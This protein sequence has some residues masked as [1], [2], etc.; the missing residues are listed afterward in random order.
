MQEKHKLNIF[1]VI[2]NESIRNKLELLLKA[3]E[4]DHYTWNKSSMAAVSEMS[5]Q[6]MKDALLIAEDSIINVNEEFKKL[7]TSNSIRFPV[8]IATN[9]VNKNLAYTLM[10]AGNEGVIIEELLSEK[11][12]DDLITQSVIRKDIETDLLERIQQ[13]V[14]KSE[15]KSIFLSNMSHEIRNPL[16]VIVGIID[17]LNEQLPPSKEILLNYVSTMDKAASSLLSLVNGI[18]DLSKIEEGKIELNKAVFN[19]WEEIK[20]PID[21]VQI[22]AKQKK[23]ALNV[24]MEPKVSNYVIGDADR[25][26][27][28]LLNLLSNAMKFTDKGSIS[29]NIRASSK[30]RHGIEFSV[31]DTGSGISEE[32]IE[33]IFNPFV[34]ENA[35]IENTHGGTGLGLAICKQLVGIMNGT[36]DVKSTLGEGSTFSFTLPLDP[37]QGQINYSSQ[38]T[39]LIVDDEVEMI[40]L[41]AALL[42]PLNIEII[43]CSQPLEALNIIE[44][45]NIDAVLTDIMM[46]DID[47]INIFNRV[48][49][50]Y[51][52]KL[53]FIFISGVADPLVKQALIAGEASI[54]D[55]PIIDIKNFVQT[56]GAALERGTIFRDQRSMQKQLMKQEGK[57]ILL[58][59]DMLE[60][61]IVIKAMLKKTPFIVECVT[62]GKQAVDRI[63]KGAFDLLLIDIHMPIMDGNTAIKEIRKWEKENNKGPIKIIALTANTLQHQIDEVMESGCDNLI[64]KPIHKKILLKGIM[65]QIISDESKKV[66]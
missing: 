54:F 8:V 39:L 18:L 28:I 34:Q 29:I 47:G 15:H 5:L 57:R 21:I 16:N 9:Q 63:K 36:L 14:N 41:M 40:D 66:S 26:N 49:K 13:A 3:M 27:Q 62:N 50:E 33:E 61:H 46:P 42:E 53:P 51:Q 19:L 48:N 22:K 44:S 31:S 24:T 30:M 17:L 2:E 64:A 55:K 60:N 35:S 65:D 7:I 38:S 6:E 43:K 58:A 1:T 52:Y 23:V 37:I 11:S 56:V 10:R 32:K 59:E 45:R 12:L 25:I 4:S 20:K